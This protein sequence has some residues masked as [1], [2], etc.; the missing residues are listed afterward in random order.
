VFAGGRAEI[1]TNHPAANLYGQMLPR[2]AWD[3]GSTGLRSLLVPTM[4]SGAF[5]CFAVG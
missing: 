2:A 5:T 4:S 3:D 1:G